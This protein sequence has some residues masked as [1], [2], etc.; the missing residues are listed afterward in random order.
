[1]R[2]PQTPE[3]IKEA[4]A[5]VLR[6]VFAGIGQVLLMTERIRR[7]AIGQ[8]HSPDGSAGARD[9]RDTPAPARSNA[10][11]ATS[12]TATAKPGN[13]KAD[14]APA[15]TA[16]PAKAAKTATPAKAAKTATP[17]K[18]AKTAKTAQPGPA[19]PAEA[20]TAGQAEVRGTGV[21]PV[22]HYSELS[23]ASLRARLRGLD[24]GQVRDLLSYERN[25]EDR[26]NVIAMFERR[27]AKLEEAEGTD[28]AAG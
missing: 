5:Q 19:T 3:R 24:I 18:A 21:L 27:I 10:T 6:A 11:D 15:T 12:A 9:T 2:I 7:R 4:P 25:H 14:A 13:A 8:E 16:T 26:A 17:A 20:A 23:I 1:M 22:P 28:P